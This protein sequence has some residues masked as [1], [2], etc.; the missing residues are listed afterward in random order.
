MA[1]NNDLGSFMA[2]IVV[3]GLVGAAVALLLAPQSGEETRTLI[4][5]K[6][7][8]LKD[9]AVEYGQESYKR[10]E[11]ALQDATARANEAIE[12]MRVRS[13]QLADMAKER[14]SEV[15]KAT[16]ARRKGAVEVEVVEEVSDEGAEAAA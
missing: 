1:E 15:Q 10:T 4:R 16:A 14:V 8:E 3:G 12:E 13:N 7:I 5:D 2:G 6:S 9:A 11:Q